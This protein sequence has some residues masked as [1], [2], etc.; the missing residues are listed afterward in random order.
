MALRDRHH[1]KYICNH[2]AWLCF[3]EADEFYKQPTFYAMAHASKFI[4]RGSSRVETFSSVAGV[5]AAATIQLDGVVT[6]LVLNR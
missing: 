5:E 3:Q 2:L 6:V 4:Q 1:S